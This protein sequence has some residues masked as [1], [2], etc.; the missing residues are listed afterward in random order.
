MSRDVLH[1]L[2]DGALV[3]ICLD[4]DEWPRGLL[5]ETPIPDK[6]M[7]LI[8]KPDGRRRFAPAGETPRADRGDRLLLVRN[9]PLTVPLEI[10]DAPSRDGL[11]I[12]CVCEIL[13][14]CPA[15]E[16]ELAQLARSMLAPDALHLN[17]LRDRVAHAG[18]D[19]GLRDFVRAHDAPALLEQ[20]RRAE[21]LGALRGALKAFLFESGLEIE[22]LGRLEFRSESYV[23]RQ[24]H[25]RQ[26]QARLEQIRAREMVESAAL[27]ATQRRLDDLSTLLHKLRAAAGAQDGSQWRQLL[28]ALSPAERGKL[29]EN[30]WRITPNPRPAA[31]IVVIA[32]DECLWLDPK[33]PSN[34]LRRSTPPSELG[35][36]RSLSFLPA[37][38][39]IA[40]GAALGVWL[41]DADA[42]ARPRAF[43]AAT[44]T[45]ART[46][47]NSAAIVEQRLYA[48]HSQLG[49]WSWS[50]EDPADARPILQPQSGVPRTVRAA[51]ALPHGR[52]AFAADDSVHVFDPRSG[53]LSVLASADDVIHALAVIDQT[54][55]AGGGDGKLLAMDL[56]VR[57][58]AAHSSSATP[59]G[60]EGVSFW[61]VLH[62]GTGPIESIHPRRWNDLIEIVIPNGPHGV[63]AVYEQEGL[64]VRLVESDAPIRRAW[65]CDDLLVGL[66]ENRDRLVVLH[67]GRPERSGEVAAIGRMTGHS[68]QDACITTTVP[69]ST[70]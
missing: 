51:T 49:C 53:G 63:C 39:Q 15:R 20:D 46:G 22:R 28:P 11:P 55:L 43:R 61:R 31:A 54:L 29:L 10:Q 4:G 30:L 6:W 17:Q 3:A 26:T 23:A 8:E 35:G 42:G 36:L 57:T 48:T 2:D 65:T 21:V 56:D 62:R 34:V 38:N 64:T 7:G 41:I 19:R 37:S 60:A 32:G 68:V 16:D 25:Q 5:S 13:V 44:T 9:R 70:A 24:A 27:A 40:I 33:Q 45:T 59:P 47:F 58:G 14:R 18:G 67:S 1:C 50:L 52:M 69:A 12:T 66:T